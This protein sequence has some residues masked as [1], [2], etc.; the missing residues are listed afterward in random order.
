MDRVVSDYKRNAL[1]APLASSRDCGDRD[2]SR[3]HLDLL[4]RQLGLVAQFV[5][6][7]L[8]GFGLMFLVEDLLEGTFAQCPVTAGTSRRWPEPSLASQSIRP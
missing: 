4:D 2:Q 5:E 3:W 6:L 7:F 8:P 1:T